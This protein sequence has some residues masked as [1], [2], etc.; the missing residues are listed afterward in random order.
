MAADSAKTVAAA[1]PAQTAATQ[2]KS[3]E[4]RS[5][6]VKSGQVKST[7]GTRHLKKMVRHHRVKHRHYAH[8]HHNKVSAMHA[9]GKSHSL[10][11]TRLGF[12]QTGH[13]VSLNKIK[14]TGAKLSFKRATPATRRG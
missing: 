13:K 2:M 8:R 7:T 1:K 10:A 6:E 5:A 14:K 4:A 11:K 12:H 3:G 9:S